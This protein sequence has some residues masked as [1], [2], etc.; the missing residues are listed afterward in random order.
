MND[1]CLCDYFY[2][3][4]HIKRKKQNNLFANNR[5]TSDYHLQTFGKYFLTLNFEKK[6]LKPVY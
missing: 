1:Y 6:S 2:I 5:N 4:S 3:K